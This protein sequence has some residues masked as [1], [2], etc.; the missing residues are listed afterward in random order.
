MMTKIAVFTAKI[1]KNYYLLLVN[2]F[3]ENYINSWTLSQMPNC[4]NNQ[5]NVPGA[6]W[7]TI[8]IRSW[9]STLSNSGL[10]IYALKPSI[11]DL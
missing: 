1:T 3:A 9:K 6:S 8:A 11:V 7:S 5:T 2:F 4:W 10:S